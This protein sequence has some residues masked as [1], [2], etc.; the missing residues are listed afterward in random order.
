M[1]VKGGSYQTSATG[2]TNAKKPRSPVEMPGGIS[3]EG[4]FCSGIQFGDVDWKF[5]EMSSSTTS[6]T[7]CGDGAGRKTNKFKKVVKKE[8]KGEKKTK[9]RTVNYSIFSAFNTPSHTKPH[10]PGLLGGGGADDKKVPNSKTKTYKDIL[11]AAAKKKA[12]QKIIAHKSLLHPIHN[13]PPDSPTSSTAAIPSDAEDDGNYDIKTFRNIE[14]SSG[15]EVVRS[16]DQEFI[17]Y[18]K[19]NPLY[20]IEN[21]GNQCFST[22]L[23]YVLF[24]QEIIRKAVIG[25]SYQ[26]LEQ[27]P[28]LIFYVDNRNKSDICK[29]LWNV[30]A[31]QNDYKDWLSPLLLNLSSDL[32]NGRQHDQHETITLLLEKLQQVISFY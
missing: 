26:I 24:S 8:W 14:Y 9:F 1:P 31:T 2:L 7:L 3:G 6:D 20:L 19:A 13:F 11:L 17:D 21:Q 30:L 18:M 4:P 5:G 29:L 12:D 22:S 23:F 27:L 25:T 16:E 15:I 28:K 10:P 32:G